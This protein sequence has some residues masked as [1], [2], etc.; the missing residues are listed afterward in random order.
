MSERIRLTPFPI[1][2][3]VIEWKN[4]HGWIEPQRPIEHPEIS[5]HRGHIFVHAEDVFPKWRTLIVGSLVEFYLYYDGQGLGAEEC[6]GR[7]VV[8]LMLPVEAAHASFG[9]E[10][11]K[12]PEFEQEHRVTVRAY[13]WVKVD[14]FPSDLPFLL[15]EIW[16]RP[17]A[18]VE[19]VLHAASPPEKAPD[20]CSA[21]L[22][23]PESRLWRLDLGLLQQCC[24]V[25]VSNETTITDPMP[26]RTLTLTGSQIDFRTGLHSLIAQE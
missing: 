3:R 25:E 7:K 1:V 26:C 11:D 10:G 18:V 14:G 21:N 22:L 20:V 15:F 8:R 6:V 23:L 17:Q 19:A 5:K 2:G 13:Q 9:E 4:S 12:L 16:G 24:K